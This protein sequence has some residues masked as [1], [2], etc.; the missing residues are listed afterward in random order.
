MEQHIH[1]QLG[2]ITA[3]S[4][5]VVVQDSLPLKSNCRCKK[6]NWICQI[7]KEQKEPLEV[8]H[9]SMEKTSYPQNTQLLFLQRKSEKV[10]P[11]SEKHLQL[12]R[13]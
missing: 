6:R 7:Y 10:S 5:Q 2:G 9:S 4:H 11:S 8:T 1:Q 3:F 13:W 12:L